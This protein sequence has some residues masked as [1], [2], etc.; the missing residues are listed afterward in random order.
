M[1]IALRKSLTVA[2]YLV[3]ADAQ[4]ER[5]RSELIN[6]QIVM[7]APER[8]AHVRT[9]IAA[10]RALGDAI[11]QAGLPW[12]ALGDGLGVR[13]DEHTVYEPDAIVYCGSRLSADALIVP[14]PIIIVE[15]LSP[16][17]AHTDT[18]AKLIGYFKLSSVQHYLIIDPEQRSLAHHARGSDGA[19]SGGPVPGENLT[20]DPPGLAIAVADLFG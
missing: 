7:M 13:I 14:N 20:L 4:T 8:A 10:V 17:T 6:G 18:S 12:E 15:V 5:V 2:D 11:E 3:W 9:K 16:T 19:I 1:N